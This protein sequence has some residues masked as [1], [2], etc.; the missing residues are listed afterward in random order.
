MFIKKRICFNIIE[1]PIEWDL[2]ILDIDWAN[3]FWATD[4]GTVGVPPNLNPLSQLNSKPGKLRASPTALVPSCFKP[5][6]VHPLKV[7][8]TFSSN[9]FT[10]SPFFKQYSNYDGIMSHKIS[11]YSSFILFPKESTYLSI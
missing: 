3:A 1:A 7:L 8:S 10:S 4:K 11:S 5:A 6:N 2:N 9:F